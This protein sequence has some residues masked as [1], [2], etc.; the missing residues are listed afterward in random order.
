MDPEV[1]FTPRIMEMEGG[2]Y[3]GHDGIREWW[4][5]LSATF[6]DFDGEVLE[7]R[8]PR[9]DCLIVSIRVQSARLKRLLAFARTPVEGRAAPSN[10]A[11]H[12][13]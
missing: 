11:L 7:V 5:N 4:R 3:R 8:E 12:G 13:Q 6:P 10:I 2:A 9:R 1:E